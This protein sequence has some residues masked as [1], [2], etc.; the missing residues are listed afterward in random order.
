MRKKI[1]LQRVKNVMRYVSQVYSSQSF[2]R[3]YKIQTNR[4]AMKFLSKFD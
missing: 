3:V 4:K 1:L 2:S